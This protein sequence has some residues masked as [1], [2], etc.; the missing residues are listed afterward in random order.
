MMLIAATARENPPQALVNFELWPC[1]RICP[2]TR[3][4]SQNLRSTANLSNDVVLSPRLR[5]C[6]Q[7]QIFPIVSNLG[8]SAMRTL[9]LIRWVAWIHPA[10]EFRLS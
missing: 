2:E 3:G 4:G 7:L 8:F 5:I 9:N 1:L 6:S 10:R